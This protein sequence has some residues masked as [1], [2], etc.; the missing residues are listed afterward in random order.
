MLRGEM[1]WRSRRLAAQAEMSRIRGTGTKDW[2]V[3][4]AATFANQ[5][6]NRNEIEEP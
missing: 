6:V 2:G 4:D 3:E 5:E 1:R